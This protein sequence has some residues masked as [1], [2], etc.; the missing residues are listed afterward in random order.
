MSKAKPQSNQPRC[1]ECGERCDLAEL[2]P[3]HDHPRRGLPDE[4]YPV[5]DH[6]GQW[7]RLVCESCLE[8]TAV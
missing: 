1:A 8:A 2:H 6:E 3:Q 5:R 4:A 7:Y